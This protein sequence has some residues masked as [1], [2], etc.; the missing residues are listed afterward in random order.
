MSKENLKNRGITLLSL[1]LTIIIM[2]I[3]TGVALSIALGENGIVEKAYEAVESTQ[4]AT[5]KELL[6]SSAIGAMGN[7]GKVN[8]SAMVLPEGFTG[9]N[10]TYTCED[11][12]TFTVSENGEIVYTGGSGL[13]D[14]TETLDLNG[15]YYFDVSIT[16]E[17]MEIVNS[18]LIR[19][20][21]YDSS[22]D[23]EDVQEWELLSIN[24]EDNII[25]FKYEYDGS[26]GV[27]TGVSSFPYIIVKENEK[28]VNKVILFDGV[29]SFQNMNGI[30]LPLDGVYFS[31]DGTRK[32][33]YT[34]NDGLP[35]YYIKDGESWSRDLINQ[36]RD[37]YCK[38]GNTYYLPDASIMQV[39]EDLSEITKSGVTWT[40]Q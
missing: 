30:S 40:K 32:V 29:F 20:V 2:L 39:S 11:G 25:E 26:G 8:L 12:H 5:D 15:K 7:D 36:D 33:E 9:S 28:I 1:I 6:L 34:L 24:E 38:I 27:V 10:G 37:G 21:Y 3:L 35:S 19:H 16:N 14:G 17:Y 13:D 23:T 31:Q 22:N 18:S 4:I